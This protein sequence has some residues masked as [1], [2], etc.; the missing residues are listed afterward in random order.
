MKILTVIYN[1]NNQQ[2]NMALESWNTIPKE[3]EIVAVTNRIV[4]SA[5][6][7]KNITY[8]E[9]DENCLAKAWN[10]GL[11]EIFKTEDIAF[12]SGLDSICPTLEEMKLMAQRVKD[13]GVGF[14]SATPKVPGLG[15]E[16]VAHVKHGD[17]SFSFFCITK[18]CF[19]R[20]G[21][22][23]EKFKPAY[24]EDN[25]YLER[26]WQQNYTPI[27]LNSVQYTHVFQASV[28]YGKRA[29]KAYGKFMNKN[30]AY[31]RKKWGKTPDHLPLDIIF[32]E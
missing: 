19:E 31:F 10:I 8:L 27:R 30:L 3:V 21:D 20:I 4:P 24:F 1:E 29:N 15:K 9:N 23:D 32:G 13:L 2:F 14:V 26:L 11:K 12:V 6:Y 5:E 28:K 7:P 17:G 16:P 22:F 18:E 25:D